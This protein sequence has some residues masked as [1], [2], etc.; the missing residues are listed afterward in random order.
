MKRGDRIRRE[1]AAVVTGRN[2]ANVPNAYQGGTF[3]YLPKG[4]G[5]RERKGRS[6]DAE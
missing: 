2:G 1:D 4:A 5:L 6:L 3:L